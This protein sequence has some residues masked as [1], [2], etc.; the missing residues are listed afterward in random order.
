MNNAGRVIG[1]TAI[2]FTEEDISTTM[3]ANFESAYHLCQL[4]HPLLKASGNGNVIFISSVASV[5]ATSHYSS[6]Y[7]ASK[8]IHFN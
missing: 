6:I 1:K 4:S 2:E 8:G 5:I 7:A 3:A